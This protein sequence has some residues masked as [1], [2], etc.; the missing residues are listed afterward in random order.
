MG[1]RAYNSQG[2]DKNGAK[3]NL[4][5]GRK[6]T[7][8]PCARAGFLGRRGF[9]INAMVR[10]LDLIDPEQNTNRDLALGV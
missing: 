7:I 3:C 8:Y 9:A 4:G 2:V 1:F 10:D 5:F 6:T